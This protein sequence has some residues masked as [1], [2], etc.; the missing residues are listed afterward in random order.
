MRKCKSCGA[1]LSLYN[2]ALLCWPCQEKKKEQLEETIGDTL[3][4][5]VEN[6]CFLLGLQNPE[7]VKR[8]GRKGLIPGRVPGI[9]QHLYLREE[10]NRWIKGQQ[11]SVSL[12]T[13]RLR[14]VGGTTADLESGRGGQLIKFRL[15]NSSGNVLTIER[16]CLE[17]LGCQSYD[18]L[19]HIGAR[20]IRLK[21]EIKL[22]PDRLGEYIITEET[23]RYEGP[24]ADDFDLV[25]DSPPGFRYNARL[26]IYY[27]DLATDKNFTLYSDAFDIYFCKEGDLLSRYI[28]KKS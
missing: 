5:T 10:V 6:L 27:S 17:V 7:S 23:F 3:H 16:I 21:Y 20:V 28:A 15:G 2:R 19:P 9:R 18:E 25:C 8:R 22:S 1:K 24:G 4:Y 12:L 14:E 13:I 11:E 26:K